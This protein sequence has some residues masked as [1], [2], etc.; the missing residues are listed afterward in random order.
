[1]TTV[2]T[3]KLAPSGEGRD[4]LFANDQ[5]DLPLEA[6]RVLVQV[7]L[8]PA[9]DARRQ[10]KLWPILLRHEAIIRSRLHE[11]FLELVID[12]DQEVAFT[13]QVLSDEFDVPV[14]LRRAPLTFLD[15]VLLLFLRRRLTQSDAQGERSVLAHQEM[16]EHLTIFER[17]GNVDRARF[18]RQV[19]NAIEKAK[20]HSLLQKIR[21]SEDRYE[22]SP[23]LKLLLP[24]EEVKSLANIYANLA[25]A[26]S[27]GASND[28]DTPGGTDSEEDS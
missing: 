2:E 6:R 25:A 8:G 9:I 19:D 13:R 3:P 11:L 26:P 21:G 16:V 14:L 17:E 4:P 18:E 22:V 15:S 24:A 23:T 5:G 7:L 28:E 20:R 1:M 10:T 12:R 27:E